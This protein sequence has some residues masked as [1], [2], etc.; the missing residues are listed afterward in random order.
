MPRL[1]S[2]RLAGILLGMAIL[3][4]IPFEDSGTIWV[5]LFSLLVCMLAAITIGSK[6]S[7][8]KRRLWYAWPA[9]GLVAGLLVT[10]TAILLMALK[11]GIHGHGSPDFTPAQVSAVLSSWPIWAM[12]GLLAGL[13]A[14]IWQRVR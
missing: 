10:P 14:S 3:L 7:L 6:I 11:S 8:A 4:W 1:P 5:R 9:V 12:S 2:L 13:A